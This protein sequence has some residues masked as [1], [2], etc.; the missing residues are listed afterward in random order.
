MYITINP[1]IIMNKSQ[2]SELSQ[3]LTKSLTKQIKRE[4]GIYFTPPSTVHNL[5]NNIISKFKENEAIRVLEPSCGSGEFISILCEKFEGKN[6]TI[7]AIEK[8]KTIFESLKPIYDNDS[9]IKLFKEDFLTYEPSEQFDLVVG[10]PPFFVMK[11][12]EVDELYHPFFDCRPNVFLLFIIKSLTH[13]KNNGILSFV[14][15]KSFLNCLYYNKTREF[16]NKECVIINIQECNDEY[17]ETKQDTIILTLEKREHFYENKDYLLNLHGFTIFGNKDTISQLNILRD[18]STTLEHMGFDVNVGNIVWNQCKD[19]LTDDS[20]QTRLIYSSDIKNN[21]LGI[22]SYD[23]PEKKNFIQKSGLTGP[24][25]IINRG[26]GTGNYSF[27]YCL[28]NIAQPYLIENHLICI[29]PKSP[30][31]MTKKKLIASYKQ[32]ITSLQ[33]NKTQ[34]FIQLY[35][36]NNAIN[37]TELKH[38]LPIFL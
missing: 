11:K 37:T 18:K 8:N 12:H 22:R 21:K 38:I 4:N 31:S 14:L 19:I 10:N 32:I 35:F 34:R 25:L 28:L 6:L 36:G 3:E 15:P 9:R 20:N 24:L 33:D 26:Y 16:L 5:L 30:E 7:E 29:R 13:L 23:N 17:I 1:K 27:Q 2:Y